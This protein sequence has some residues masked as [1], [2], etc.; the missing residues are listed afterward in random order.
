MAKAA[1]MK[2]SG[3]DVVSLGAG[4]PDFRP[5][6]PI[7]RAG[8]RAIEQGKT[9][10]TATSG[11]PELRAA[12]ARWLSSAFGLSYAADEVMVCAGAKAALHMALDA[13]SNPATPVLSWRRTGSRTRPLVTMGRR[14]TPRR[15]AAAR[16]RLVHG[17]AAIDAAVPRCTALRA[18]CCNFRTTRRG[19]ATRAQVQAIVDVAAGTTSGSFREDLRDAALRRRCARSSAARCRSGTEPH[20]RSVNGFTKSHSLT[21]WRT[22]FLAGPA[23]GRRRPRAASRARCSAT[24]ARSARRRARRRQQPLPHEHEAPHAGVRRTAAATCVAEINRIPGLKLTAPRGAFYALVDARGVCARSAASTTSGALSTAATSTCSRPCRHRVRD[25]GFIRLSYA[26][27]MDQLRTRR[28]CARPRRRSERRRGA[29]IR[30]VQ[31]R[32]SRGARRAAHEW[33][34]FAQLARVK[35]L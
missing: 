12:G 35:E 10:Y 33:D 30:V 7:A 3:L 32:Q 27:R 18:S 14:R 20:G 21:G 9:R 28:G 25:P 16:A 1:R 34:G 23:R 6:D 29:A 31:P 13:M 11:I 4:E 5:P 22:S 19:G 2:Q 8:I 26:R 24:R 15:A 17:A